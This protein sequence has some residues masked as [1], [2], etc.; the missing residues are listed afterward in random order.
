MGSNLS[1]GGAAGYSTVDPGAETMTA[2]SSFSSVSV[3]TMT[4]HSATPPA[5][6]S[7]SATVKTT[8]KAHVTAPAAAK[9]TVASSSWEYDV[10]LSLRGEVRH[11]FLSNLYNA[12]TEKGIRTYKD[13]R[14][15]D[16]GKIITPAL[17]K[18]I[19]ESRFCVVVLSKNYGSSSFC[20][21]ELVK[22]TERIPD[23]ETD[24]QKYTMKCTVLPIFYNVDPSD[25]RKQT[26]EFGKK[27]AKS[28]SKYA[29]KV[30]GWK[31]ALI[32]AGNKSGWDARD[33]DIPTLIDEIVIYILKKLSRT[34]P[35]R[36]K[37][38]VGM[39]S[40]IEEMKSK[41]R[42][43]LD[44]VRIVGIWGMGGI[45]KTTIAKA[46]Y[47]SIYCQFKNYCFLE[48][49]GK[50]A[51]TFGL[52]HL[53][54]QLLS[55][56]LKED[57][58]TIRN[59]G[60]NFDAIRERL[61]YMRVL[62]VLDGVDNGEEMEALA[63]DH[64]WFGPGSRII[65]TTTDRNLL[66]NRVDE[67]YE[68]KGLN[69]NESLSLFTQYAVQN[70]Y[71]VDKFIKFM[72]L[73]RLIVKYAEGVPL[74]LKVL[75]SFLV[76]KN[77]NEWQSELQKL[78]KYPNIKIQQVLRM[79]YD[80][81]DDPQ[82]Y[83]FLDIACFFNGE[84]KSYVVKVLEGC[85]F[86]ADGSLKA[87][88]DK[89]LITILD[90]KIWMNGLLQK[91]GRDIVR[92]ESP[93]KPGDRS[94]L[95]DHE[96]VYQVLK[97]NAATDNIEGM[98]L[99]LSKV[100]NLVID[101]EVFWRMK[102]LR[103]LKICYVDH[104]GG[105]EYL[106]QNSRT[107]AIRP[108]KKSRAILYGDFS[109]LSNDLR[110]LYWHGCPQDLPSKFY[111]VNP[112][113]LNMS[114][115]SITKLPTESKCFDNLRFIKLSHCQKLTMTPDFY[116]VQ[117]LEILILEGCKS[118]IQVHPSLGS[119]KSLRLLNLKDCS[120]LQSF[121]SEL[122][123]IS[124]EILILS[125][126]SLLNKFPEI[127]D[128]MEILSELFLDDTAIQALPS[129]IEKLTGLVLLSAKNCK[130]LWDLPTS[131]GH[132]KHLKSTYFSGCPNHYTLLKELQ[133]LE[134][135]EELYLDKV[136]IKNPPLPICSFTKLKVLSF[137]ECENFPFVNTEQSLPEENRENLSPYF[138]G[139]LSCLTSLDL[140]YCNLTEV[141]IPKE[142]GLLESLKELNL[143]GNYFYTLPSQTFAKLKN[144]Q[145]I[146][147][148][149][150]INLVSV[151]SLPPKTHCVEAQNCPELVNVA[152][153]LKGS[154]KS[155]FNFMN[156]SNLGYV[157]GEKC[158]ASAIKVALEL[159][160]HHVRK[161]SF[162]EFTVI[163]PGGGI[164]VWSEHEQS[165]P[166]K[167]INLPGDWYKESLRG[168]AFWAVF[169]VDDYDSDNGTAMEMQCGFELYLVHNASKVIPDTGFFIN[170]SSKVVSDHLGLHYIP[171]WS[172]STTR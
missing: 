87:L 60:S 111:P 40:R 131:I 2:P 8:H 35:K 14:S 103:V 66:A 126:C 55:K 112:V 63:A 171:S 22:I 67:I 144:L 58:Q 11:E 152:P 168:L 81:L 54:E 56:L 160:K 73:S 6:T 1:T 151:P 86:H 119:L 129:S 97:E 139:S 172:F 4:A 145:V 130:Y 161:V 24:A 59:L 124:L 89:C 31:L 83:T 136:T 74:A 115:S 85:G 108:P 163:I 21:D 51:E 155:Y 150:C 75:G 100:D 154:C 120:L 7:D 70:S 88:V 94:R 105:F 135:L 28:K 153:R 113:E 106:T 13:D 30:E 29:E 101:T 102:R 132:L 158:E 18:A 98:I 114:Y 23:S 65:I 53:Q 47:D 34:S 147:L 167:S 17:L 26:G 5:I 123:T 16:K 15:L 79:S 92:Q 64:D 45:G 164:P 110:C 78:K 142:F 125:G 169:E 48:R 43:G 137:R 39:D 80:G 159:L 148:A 9:V 77:E 104:S 95:W 128:N 36:A 141:S 127:K 20:L 68:P 19:Q 107:Y 46:V 44:D 49:V 121:P 170:R 99:D 10:F 3:E 140:S 122:R 33:R 133:C 42:L 62:I 52:Q 149:E 72:E 162:T 109:K 25:V 69:H 32:K 71:P 116:G 143:S 37:G 27:F 117:K 12:L 61:Q 41:L 38:L 57:I 118:L 84:D 50:V 91:M 93:R 146:C 166:S 134:N 156:C 165:H 76:P 82:K 96:D 138:Y 90:N 157:Y